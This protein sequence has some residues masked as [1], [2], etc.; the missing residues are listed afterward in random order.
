M[1]KNWG[2]IWLGPSAAHNIKLDGYAIV[3][4]FARYQT[5]IFDRRMGFQAAVN[6]LTNGRYVGNG[7]W[8]APREILFYSDIKF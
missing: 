4:V 5:R 1:V 3:N 7:V 8:N 2:P 6:N